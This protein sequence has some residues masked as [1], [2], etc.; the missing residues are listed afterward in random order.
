MFAKQNQKKR[1]TYHYLYG[2]V[3]L[4]HPQWTVASTVKT[5]KTLDL[6][7]FVFLGPPQST[8]LRALRKPL[9]RSLQHAVHR[10]SLLLI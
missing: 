8:M 2:F 9:D 5:P 1:S 7:G 4:G 10:N 3:F 6:Y